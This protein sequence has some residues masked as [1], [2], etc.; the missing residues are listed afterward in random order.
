MFYMAL[1]K[2]GVPA[3]M[4]I[5]E[6]GPHGVG[7]RRRTRR[8]PPGRRAWRTGC[9]CAACSTRRLLAGTGKRVALTVVPLAVVVVSAHAGTLSL[10]TFDGGGCSDG[11]SSV[12][13]AT[14]V[15][16]GVKFTGTISCE[17]STIYFGTSGGTASI[18]DGDS[19]L[20]AWNFVV[21]EPRLTSVDWYLE[22]IG[23]SAKGAIV[24][25]EKISGS[26]G[27]DNA[28]FQDSEIIGPVV[29]KK[30]VAYSVDLE[31]DF[32]RSSPPGPPS[33]ISSKGLMRS[34]AKR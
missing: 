27:P 31:F 26:G 14:S 28:S 10:A 16:H 32:F 21:K 22:V 3:E 19:I 29:G 13:D 17:A 23:L 15:S 30:M 18:P 12:G 20:V 6:R 2:A 4:H 25:D 5:Y 1:R 7:W 34:S 24:L 11:T 9:A 8:S 33:W